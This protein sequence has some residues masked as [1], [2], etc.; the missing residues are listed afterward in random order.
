MQQG[1]QAP[2]R[3]QPRSDVGGDLLDHQRVLGDREGVLADGLAVPAR[4]A[5]QAVGDVLD[6][7]VERRGIEQVEATS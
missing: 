5:G 3:L 2:F 4:D 7:D 1:G 6:L